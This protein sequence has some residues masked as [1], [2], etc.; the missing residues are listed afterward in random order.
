L[1]KGRAAFDS[2]VARGKEQ[3]EMK[4][5]LWAVLL[6]AVTG[7]FAGVDG[8]GASGSTPTASVESIATVTGQV[9]VVF[10]FDLY[11]CPAGQPITITGWLANQPSRPDS[12]AAASGADYGVS[13]GAAVQHLTL[14]ANQNGFLA[15]D[16]WV[17]S[18]SVNCGAVMIPV[19]GGGQT[20]S[21][22][23]GV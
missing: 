5:V 10:D 7:A 4:R 18:G 6:A 14:E 21:V 22:N 3:Y 1:P 13:N 19:S 12:G 11:N 23:G 9:T 16:Q 2:D 20:K 17:G 15:G 8:A